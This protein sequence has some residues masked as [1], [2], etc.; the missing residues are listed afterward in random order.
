MTAGRNIDGGFFAIEQLLFFAKWHIVHTRHLGK[1]GTRVASIN[2]GIMASGLA[3]TGSPGPEKRASH[4]YAVRMP[5]RH[6]D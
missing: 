2:I 5:A 1:G 4:L 3:F 6:L